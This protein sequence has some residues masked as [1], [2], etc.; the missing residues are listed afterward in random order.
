MMVVNKKKQAL[1]DW[2]AFLCQQFLDK[3]E[4]NET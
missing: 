2:K 3:G 4:K 1:L